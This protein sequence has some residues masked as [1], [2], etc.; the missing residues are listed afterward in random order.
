MTGGTGFL[1]TELVPM[2]ATEF[3]KVVVL[4][5]LQSNLANPYESLANVEFIKYDPDNPEKL[6]VDLD[7]VLLHL[8]WSDLSDFNNKSHV[9]SNLSSSIALVDKFISREASLISVVGTCMEYGHV[10]GPISPH[11]N[12]NPLNMYALGKDTLHKYLTMRRSTEAFRLQWGRAFYLYGANETRNT[13]LNQLKACID[14]NASE[15]PMSGGEQ[16]RDYIPVSKAAAMI[17]KT[18]NTQENR[19]YNISTGKPISLRRLVE[20]YIRLNQ[21]T[22]KPVFGAYPYP[23]NEP[24]AFWGEI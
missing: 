4:S 12:T 7:S 11:T 1:G 2:V 15:F 16:L 24:F 19:T 13:V 21:A 8:G 23:N 5:R 3:D 22:I 14:N 20:D 6:D 10:Y 17:V 18:L 9:E